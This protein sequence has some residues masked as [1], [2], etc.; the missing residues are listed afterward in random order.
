MIIEE[1]QAKL[2]AA[3]TKRKAILSGK[4]KIIDG[5]HILTTLEM[6]GYLVVEEKKD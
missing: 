3:V 4:R 1:K 5:K 2:R 6:H